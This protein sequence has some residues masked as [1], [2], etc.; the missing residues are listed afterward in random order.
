[1]SGDSGAPPPKKKRH[2]STGLEMLDPAFGTGEAS[3]GYGT[4]PTAP[5]RPGSRVGK[6]KSGT[7][8]Q[9][10]ISEAPDT[11]VVQPASPSLSPPTIE[12]G[13]SPKRKPAKPRQGVLSSY[14]PPR[15]IGNLLQASLGRRR[16][17]TLNPRKGGRKSPDEPEPVEEKTHEATVTLGL[18][19]TGKMSPWEQQK[20]KG[21]SQLSPS[22]Q[23]LAA[24]NPDW[25]E[26]M[27]RDLDRIVAAYNLERRKMQ[28]ESGNTSKFYAMTIAQVLRKKSGLLQDTV[29]R[30][31]KRWRLPTPKKKREKSPSP[32][33][34]IGQ[35]RDRPDQPPRTLSALSSPSPTPE[36]APEPALH[37]PAADLF[38]SLSLPEVPDIH[39]PPADQMI[40]PPTAALR[41]SPSSVASFRSSAFGGIGSDLRPGTWWNPVM[42]GEPPRHGRPV[43]PT[44]SARRGVIGHHPLPQHVTPGQHPSGGDPARSLSSSSLRSLPSTA[45]SDLINQRLQIQAAQT[46]TLPERRGVVSG[47]IRRSR[48]STAAS[49]DRARRRMLNVPRGLQKSKQRGLQVLKR[50]N[51]HIEQQGP[52]NLILHA[53]IVNRGV[54]DQIRALVTK[55]T[56]PILVENQKVPKKQQVNHIAH[57]L[58]KHNHV[59]ITVVDS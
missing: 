12:Y 2:R 8:S 55:I 45:T 59:R 53:R 7:V 5:R 30:H 33:P 22:I 21:M 36:P 4:Q 9:I 47:S 24:Q 1:M 37:S 44:N 32:E 43:S 6:R 20:Q 3:I 19:A 15:S 35:L 13:S 52:N 18:P 49:F 39:P 11:P 25:S 51:F 16:Y 57:L 31:V 48:S 40:L 41:S 42:P 29:D 10:D 46:N 38:E 27:M 56:R 54:I 28:H 26:N 17:E 58:E 14:M 50:Q 23:R 34:A